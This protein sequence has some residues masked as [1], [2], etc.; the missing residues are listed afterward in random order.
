[1]LGED[2]FGDGTHVGLGHAMAA[3]RF[4]HLKVVAEAPN[5]LNRRFGVRP[6]RRTVTRNPEDVCELG[7]LRLTPDEAPVKHVWEHQADQA[8]VG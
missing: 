4:V 7:K 5:C 3:K 6:D 2:A 1:M 8:P